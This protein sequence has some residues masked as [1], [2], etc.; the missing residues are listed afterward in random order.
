M[1]V[2][3]AHEE[4]VVAVLYLHEIGSLNGDQVG[5]ALRLNQFRRNGA[6]VN[7]WRRVDRIGAGRHQIHILT[8]YLSLSGRLQRGRRIVCYVPDAVNGVGFVPMI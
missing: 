1:L 2:A 6:Q 3:L 5:S 8:G 7:C 4:R